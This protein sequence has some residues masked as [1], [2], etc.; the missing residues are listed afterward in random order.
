[1]DAYIF[2]ACS[3]LS[4]NERVCMCMYVQIAMIWRMEGNDSGTPSSAL[5]LAS[6]FVFVLALG[7]S[8]FVFVLA[9]GSS[10]FV[11]VLA[12]GR[13]V[14]PCEANASLTVTGSI[15]EIRLERRV[16]CVL[17]QSIGRHQTQ[18]HQR[19][20]IVCHQLFISEG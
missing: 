19:S 14:Q 2:L 17:S 11:F 6:V 12:L 4:E 10:V 9:L 1:M 18:R 16:D 7:S 15:S 8:V 5:W 20:S 13:R 3:F